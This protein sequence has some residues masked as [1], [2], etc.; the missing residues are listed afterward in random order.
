MK[1][2]KHNFLIDE[3]GNNKLYYNSFT[4]GLAE[5]DDE[6][7]GILSKIE[8]GV[9]DLSDLNERQSKI[10]NDLILGHF[11]TQSDDN[12]FDEVKFLY[13]KEMF[14]SKGLG[15]TILP[16]L[17][18]NFRCVYCYEKHLEI[19]MSDGVIEKIKQY[20]KD[21]IE[22]NRINF[23]FINWYG[24]EPLLKIDTIRELS[25][26][27]IDICK[28]NNCKYSADIVSN[29]WLVDDELAKELS[30]LHIKGFQIT[31]DGTENIHNKYRKLANGGS[32]YQKIIESIR[33][34]SKYLEI[35]V[36][37]NISKEFSNNLAS[38]FNELPKDMLSIPFYPAHMSPDSTTV[39]QSIR[40]ICMDDKQFAEK[41][42][43][44]FEIAFSKGMH[45]TMYPKPKVGGC[46]ANNISSMIIGPDGSLYRCWAQ[47]GEI[48]ESYG[49][50]MDFNNTFKPE[51]Y[52]KWVLFDPFAIEECKDCSVFP[53]CVAGCPAKWIN[54]STD[55]LMPD[56][57]NKCTMFK[58][59]LKEF[60]QLIYKAK[61]SKLSE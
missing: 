59:N 3:I 44:F 40:E 28:K 14:S 23:L 43:E 24:G 39:C 9:I 20:V 19:D 7:Q 60:L 37:V 1:I 51:N 13:T 49:N 18:C 61:T 22:N 11:V 32:T 12:L 4:G 47:V 41:Q 15:L 27:F 53:V 6:V 34:L 21:Q 46:C 2:S 57:T 5:F 38:F 36:R 45:I 30:E 26:F 52:Y 54:S 58:Y 35:G 17:R 56:K 29:G 42:V 48:N 31:I 16:T 33:I 10:I 25:L 8:T 55:Y 50:I